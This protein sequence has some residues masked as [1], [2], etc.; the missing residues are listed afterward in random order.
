MIKLY[1]S[2]SGMIILDFSDTILK[3]AARIDYHDVL[4][5]SDRSY[6][7]LHASMAINAFIL[8]V[9]AASYVQVV[10]REW[11]SYRIVENLPGN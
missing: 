5:V 4:G 6:Q 1:F 3:S 11:A 9:G 2:H 10:Q 7:K 8:F